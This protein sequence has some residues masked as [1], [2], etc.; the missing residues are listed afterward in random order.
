MTVSKQRIVTRLLLRLEAQGH[1]EHST[2]RDD[3]CY[4][5]VGV[6]RNGWRL[7]AGLIALAEERERAIL[8]PFSQQK[9]DTL[10]DILREL[11]ARHR[12]PA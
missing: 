5:L 3:R 10:K 6:T 9:I 12:P 2:S 11:I 1:V 7:V 4:T 8:E